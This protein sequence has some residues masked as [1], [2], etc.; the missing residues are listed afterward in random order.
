MITRKPRSRGE[1]KTGRIDAST[2]R[3]IRQGEFV[4]REPVTAVSKALSTWKEI[5]S[6]RKVERS[7]I[8]ATGV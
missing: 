4:R 8:P 6:P 1:N 2:L 7:G 5:T 3:R